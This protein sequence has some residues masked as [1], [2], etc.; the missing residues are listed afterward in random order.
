MPQTFVVGPVLSWQGPMQLLDIPPSED[1]AEK[2]QI[3]GH[4]GNQ[5]KCDEGPHG[6]REKWARAVLPA[7]EGQMG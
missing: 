3:S 7:M 5:D 4:R 2:Y 1:P 6:G